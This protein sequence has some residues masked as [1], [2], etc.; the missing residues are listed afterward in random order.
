MRSEVEIKEVAH[1]ADLLE[2]IEEFPEGLDTFWVNAV[3]P[4][5]A[6]RNNEPRSHAQS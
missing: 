3:K 5:Q 4:S 2:Q 1:T 6:D